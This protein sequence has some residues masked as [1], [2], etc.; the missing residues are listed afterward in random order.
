M[1]QRLAISPNSRTI[2]NAVAAPLC[3]PTGC[4]MELWTDGAENHQLRKAFAL[5]AAETGVNYT[6]KHRDF[7]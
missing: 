7:C 3:R 2:R 6:K 5:A 4:E 1:E